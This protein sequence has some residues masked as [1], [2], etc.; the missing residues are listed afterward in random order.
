MCTS[1]APCPSKGAY[2][3][4]CEKTRGREA[5]HSSISSAYH[6]TLQTPSRTREGNWSAASRRAICAEGQ[7][8]RRCFSTPSSILAF[9]PWSST[10]SG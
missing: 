3:A 5:I 6:A 10:V 1:D 8:L 9:S 2:H 7:E 4:A